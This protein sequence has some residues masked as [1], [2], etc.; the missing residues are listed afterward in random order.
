MATLRTYRISLDQCCGAEIIFFR[1]GSDFQKVSAPAPAPAPAPEPAPAPATA[2]ELPVV[3]DFVLKRTFFMF[4][5]KE[6]DLIHML[7]PIQ[8]EF[9]FF[10][11]TLVDPEP[12]PG[13]GAG[14]ET[15]IIRLR[16]RLQPKVSAPCGSGSSSTTLHATAC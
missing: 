14:A 9:R 7:D 2:L 1:S 13:A 6:T 8:Y 3:T 4:L 12:E 10:Q 11:N 5:M 16:L 15:S